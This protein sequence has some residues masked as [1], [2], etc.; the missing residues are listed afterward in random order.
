MKRKYCWPPIGAVGGQGA[1]EGGRAVEADD[2]GLVAT[3]GVQVQGV[4]EGQGGT[5]GGIELAAGGS[6]K[7]GIAGWLEHGK[8]CVQHQG[9]IHAALLGQATLAQRQRQEDR[10]RHARR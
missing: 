6:G 10:L 7:A 4:Q 8:G 3:V 5:A 2:G 1:E 9:D